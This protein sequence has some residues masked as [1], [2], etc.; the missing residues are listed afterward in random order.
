MAKPWSPLCHSTYPRSFRDTV[1]TVL[2][3]NGREGTVPGVLPPPLWMEVCVCV[4]A[5]GWCVVGLLVLCSLCVRVV[6]CF[7][8][9]CV[10]IYM[11]VY[12]VHVCVC[13]CVCAICLFFVCMLCD[14]FCCFAVCVCFVLRAGVCVKRGFCV[15]CLRRAW[16]S[17]PPSPSPPLLYD[18]YSP[19]AVL[20]LIHKMASSYLS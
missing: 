19:A 10:Y 6:V 18:D 14:V 12:S 1:L 15:G 17:P 2:M 20:Q 8:F 9:G 11:C 16:I 4:C 5:A 7:G 13:F 3:A